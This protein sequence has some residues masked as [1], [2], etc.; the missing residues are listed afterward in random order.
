MAGRFSLKVLAP[1]CV[2]TQNGPTNLD[3]SFL[4]T[5]LSTGWH[6]LSISKSLTWIVDYC[7]ALSARVM[8]F[9]LSEFLFGKWSSTANMGN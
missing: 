6:V 2:S 4:I 8:Y 7:R 3:L 9:M 1:T 5:A